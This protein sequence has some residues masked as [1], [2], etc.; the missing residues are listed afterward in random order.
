MISPGCSF[1]FDGLKQVLLAVQPGLEPRLKSVRQLVINYRTTKDVLGLANAVLRTIQREFPD[2]IYVGQPET[3]T[4]DLGTKV[5]LCDWSTVQAEKLTLGH[6]Q[7]LIYSCENNVE[8]G[9]K[10]EKWLG[11]HPFILSTLDSKG[12]E[13]DDV[14]VCFEMDRK[15]WNVSARL[16]PSLRMLRELYVAITRAR[17]RV[18]ILLRQNVTEML[19]FFKSLGHPFQ[20]TNIEGILNEFKVETSLEKWR[21]KGMELYRDEKFVFAARCFSNACDHA[22]SSWSEGRHLERDGNMIDALKAFEAALLEFHDRKEFTEITDRAIWLEKRTKAWVERCNFVILGALNACPF[23]VKCRSDFL[24]VSLRCSGWELLSVSD[25][26][27]EENA[28]I[29]LQYRGHA[30]LM[31]LVRTIPKCDIESVERNLPEIIGD[32]YRDLMLYDEAVRLFLAAS[33]VESAKHTTIKLLKLV[34]QENPSTG[35]TVKLLTSAV[36]HWLGMQFPDPLSDKRIELLIILFQNPEAA[37][38]GPNGSEIVNHLGRIIVLVAVDHAK[39][40]RMLL[41]DVNSS[42]FHNDVIDCLVKRFPTDPL[43][44][45]KWFLS[46]G[47]LTR[48]HN[49]AKGSMSTWDSCELV[50]L[51][52]LLYQSSDIG[53]LFEKIKEKRVYTRSMERAVD[54]LTELIPSCAVPAPERSH[55]V[56]QA[57]K[58]MPTWNF[59]SL[60]NICIK[61]LIEAVTTEKQEAKD[62]ILRHCRAKK[63]FKHVIKN[64]TKREL[65]SIEQLVP[66]IVGDLYRDDHIYDE[67]VRM[68]L[69][70]SEL[71]NAARTTAL[72]I[73]EVERS[74]SLSGNPAI[75]ERLLRTVALWQTKS[76]KAPPR[77]KRVD[78]LLRL[79]RS[80]K[81]ELCGPNGEGIV[82]DLGQTVTLL[83][84][85]NAKLDR[86]LLGEFA[87]SIH[88]LVD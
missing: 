85:E 77:D 84:I 50:E 30:E 45:V 62:R 9:E 51:V 44:V 48:A 75:A 8:F 17:R 60:K 40:D 18:I 52:V 76:L 88:P 20:E 19:S 12:L 82:N 10:M 37:L 74:C 22:W 73:E 32:L 34:R 66:G 72:L 56:Q 27:E 46:K 41:Y 81:E 24:K 29:L 71:G 28:L 26:K 4:K 49:F 33:D 55:E 59:N 14:I 83:A 58:D 86:A 42:I 78:L 65:R 43:E 21:E 5:V 61:L 68:Y 39:L 15:V 53:W 67:A 57:S 79:F 13:F 70:A 1:T 69:K 6:N 63:G 3:A 11:T 54:C 16:V 35:K 36:E 25:L 7:A 23:H 80:P 38:Q 31:S 64:A 47:D 87:P 2:S